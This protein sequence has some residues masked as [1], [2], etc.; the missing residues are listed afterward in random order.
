MGDFIV[1]L[2]EAG[3]HTLEI[4]DKDFPIFILVAFIVERDYYIKEISPD[5]VRVKYDFFNSEGIILHSRDIRKR[6]GSFLILM[7]PEVRKRFYQAINEVMKQ[8]QYHLISC[9]IKKQE[10]KEKYG[11]FAENPYDLSMKI[12]L[13][14]LIHFCEKNDLEGVHLIAES[15]GKREDDALRL[16]FLKVILEGTEYIPKEKFYR[17]DP[18][19]EF[20][21]KERNIIGH[22][23]ADL[24][25][26]PIGRKTLR[27]DIENIPFEIIKNKFY[28]GNSN[29]PDKYGL[30]VFP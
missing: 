30:K 18:K 29:E 25:A 26:Y 1:F 5:V 11:V 3:D 22:Q 2:D 24:V 7:N 27:P 16:T 23:L 15:R 14:R 13:E 8:N 17:I 19:L 9:V 6:Q 21:S 20:H 10:H 28:G 4:V 12:I